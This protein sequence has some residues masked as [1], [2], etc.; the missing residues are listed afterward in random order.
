MV[1]RGSIIAAGLVVMA[2]ILVY[3]YLSPGEEK[4]VK[5]Q[6][7]LLSQYTAK[8]PGEDPFSTANRI[9]NLSRLFAENCEFKIE[10]D[11]LYSL[12]GSYSRQEV[13]GYAIRGRSYFSDLSLTFHDLKVRFPEKGSALV[14]VTSKLTGRSAAGEPVD[15]IREFQC[16]LNKIEK[17]WLFSSLEAV[18]VLKR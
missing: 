5:K 7:S 15:E 10:G 9:R 13:A 16:V 6:F 18:E 3:F 1:K 17:K 12:S 8:E 14:H 11:S 4:R 2:G